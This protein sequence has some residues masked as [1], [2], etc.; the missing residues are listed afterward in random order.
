MDEHFAEVLS[1][2]HQRMNTPP[3]H[4]YLKRHLLSMYLTAMAYNPTMTLAFLEQKGILNDF[5]E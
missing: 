4:D 1:I 2:V 3:M 5:F